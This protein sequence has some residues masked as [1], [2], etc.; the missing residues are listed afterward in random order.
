MANR[1]NNGRVNMKI[2][3]SIA[4]VAAILSMSSVAHAGTFTAAGNHAFSGT[5]AVE[6]D[7]GVFTC[8]MNANISV[9]S[10][11]DTSASSDASLTGGFPCDLILI[12]GGPFNTTTNGTDITFHNVNIVPPLSP[13]TC[14]GN[15]TGTVGGSA[16]T[17]TISFNTTIPSTGSGAPCKLLGTVSQ[18]PGNFNVA[19]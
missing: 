16:T 8:T 9:A 1:N 3:T 12:S 13:T 17:R 6:K 14:F 5:V 18:T 4:T 11:G 7:M 2:V 10:A 15:L 19:P